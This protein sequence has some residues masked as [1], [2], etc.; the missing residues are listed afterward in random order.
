MRLSAHLAAAALSA[1]LTGCGPS[2]SNAVDAKPH[3]TVASDDTATHRA[4]RLGIG[5]DLK[6]KL[7]DVATRANGYPSPGSRNYRAPL[8]ERMERDDE[9]HVDPAPDP[10]PPGDPTRPTTDLSAYR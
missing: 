9:A 1:S 5:F 6:E 3:A 10:R 7:N 2:R 4:D 8:S